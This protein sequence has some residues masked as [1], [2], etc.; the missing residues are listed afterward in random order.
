MDFFKDIFLLL[1]RI[2]IGGMFLWAAYEK[3][4]YWNTTVSYMKAKKIPQLNMVLPVY[5]AVQILG[6]LSIFLGW[7]TQV[8]TLLLLVAAVP[9]VLKLHAF[10]EL[11]GPEAKVEQVIFMK[12]VGLIGALLILLAVGGGHFGFSGA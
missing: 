5:V 1:G 9:A 2:C 6:G 7:Y 3:V 8:G 10:W 11:T 12:E 4:R